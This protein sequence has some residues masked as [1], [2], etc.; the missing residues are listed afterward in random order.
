MIGLGVI[1]MIDNKRELKRILD[2]EAKKYG[3]KWFFNLPFNMTEKQVLYKHSKYLR[4][5]EYAYNRKSLFR[6]LSLMRLRRLQIRYGI[7]ISLNTV[8]EGFYIE[9]L[10]S[11]IINDKAVIGKNL[12]VHPG[13]VI[14]DNHGKAPKIGDD[15]YIGPGAKV[16]GDVTLADNIQVGANAVVTKS[17]ENKGAIL[18]GIPASEK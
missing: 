15:V 11:V 9:H 14:G 1:H 12:K 3:K 6:H 2:I 7:A 16:F 17:C 18:V 5:A 4:K 8:G 13:V 10:G